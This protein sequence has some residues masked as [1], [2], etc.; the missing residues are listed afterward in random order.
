MPIYE[1]MCG[2]CLK[3]T[4]EFLPI[5]SVKQLTK[6]RFCDLVRARR[7]IS[8][9]V[10]KMKGFSEKNGYSKEKENEKNV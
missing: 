9:G 3:I 10:Y 7:I 4:S 5:S 1:F 8:S 6:C 2:N